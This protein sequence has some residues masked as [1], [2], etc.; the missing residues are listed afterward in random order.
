MRTPL[1]ILTLNS[2]FTVQWPIELRGDN[3]G[4]ANIINAQN[5]FRFVCVLLV[6][7][8]VQGL[9]HVQYVIF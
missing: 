8:M 7:D 5:T 3:Q 1:L 4:L 9:I 6:S 2:P